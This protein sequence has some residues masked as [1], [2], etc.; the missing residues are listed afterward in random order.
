MVWLLFICFFLIFNFYLALCL[1][2]CV[3]FPLIFFIL[4]Y[5]IIV[6]VKVGV[7]AACTG[8]GVNMETL[9]NQYYDLTK[10]IFNNLQIC[11]IT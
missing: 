9:E 8:W 11:A 5:L 6:V 4:S 1:F 10:N 2:S 3:S 7:S